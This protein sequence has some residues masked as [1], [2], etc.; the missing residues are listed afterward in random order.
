VSLSRQKSEFRRTNESPKRKGVV[1]V[2]TS[3]LEVGGTQVPIQ[4]GTRLRYVGFPNKTRS[5]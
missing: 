2:L 5:W 4:M 1:E 3:V